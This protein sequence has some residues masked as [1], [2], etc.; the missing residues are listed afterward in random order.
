MNRRVDVGTVT[1]KATAVA[2]AVS[3]VTKLSDMKPP[4]FAYRA[5][6]TL[7]GPQLDDSSID[8]G[9]D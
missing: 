9:T 7:T 2:M 1:V 5:C 8:T 4:D 6:P 3:H